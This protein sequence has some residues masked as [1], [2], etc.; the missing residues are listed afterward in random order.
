MPDIKNILFIKLKSMGD[1]V[2]T[3]PALDLL[4]HN[5]PNARITYLTSAENAPIVAC[6]TEV[7]EVL[8]LDRK[9]FKQGKV[10]AMAAKTFDLIRRLRR[11]RFSL[12]IDFQCYSETAAMG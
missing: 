11:G 8:I 4:R 9:I 2:F 5:F 3:L 12:V 10:V 6:F 1:V 7:D